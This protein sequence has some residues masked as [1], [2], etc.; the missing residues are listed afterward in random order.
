VLCIYSIDKL[1]PFFQALYF[2]S[3]GEQITGFSCSLINI[4]PFQS[5]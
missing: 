3:L 1:S 4:Y 2:M 5:R